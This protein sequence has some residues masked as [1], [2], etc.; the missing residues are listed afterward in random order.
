M[1]Y[2]QRA[3]VAHDVPLVAE[4]IGAVLRRRGWPV[5]GVVTNLGELEGRVARAGVGV[6]VVG[7][8]A[9]PVA[10]CAAAARRAAPGVAIVALAPAA[11]EVLRELRSHDVQ[12]MVALNAEPADLLAAVDDVAA[13]RAHVGRGLLP[14]VVATGWSPTP[15]PG[16]LTE[17]QREIV[18]LLA[19]GLPQREI[20][21]RL[22]VSPSTVKSHVTK[23]YE[24]L[25][26]ANRHEA[27]VRAVE[28]GLLA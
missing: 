18:G 24:S 9:T 3:L 19:E 10:S 8:S 13:G 15:E 7:S 21:A 1:A 20:A 22:Y 4:G 28:L 27:V 2:R 14:A 12:G 16:P 6:V 5:A 25:R 17:R 11:P 23:L 26:V